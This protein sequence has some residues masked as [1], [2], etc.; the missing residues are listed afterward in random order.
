MIHIGNKIKEVVDEKGVSVVQ[1]AKNIN[2]SRTVVYNIFN[3]ESIDSKLLFIISKE[4]N[5]N[6]F[7][8]YSPEETKL[9]MIKEN[10]SNPGELFIT[11]Y[12]SLLEKYNKLLEKHIN[13]K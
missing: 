11:K 2:K 12:Y 1:F 9:S 10:E 5:F 4:L 6:F 8:L 7:N 13:R 3:R